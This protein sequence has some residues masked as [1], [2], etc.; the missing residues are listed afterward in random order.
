M[1][2]S[3]SHI[4]A[5]SQIGYGAELVSTNGAPATFSFRGFSVTTS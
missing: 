2:D 1:L 4:V 3:T 5:L